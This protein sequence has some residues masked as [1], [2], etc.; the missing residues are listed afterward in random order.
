MLVGLNTENYGRHPFIGR[1]RQAKKMNH[2]FLKKE[3][4]NIDDLLEITRI[5][6]APGGCHWDAEQTHESVKKNLIEETYEVVEAINK[7]DTELLKEE[8]GDVLLQVVFHTQMEQEV[9]AFTFDEVC[10]GVCKKLIIRHP[11]VF[12]D[13][14][15]EDTDTILKNWDEIK[16][17]VKGQKSQSE[18]MDSI[19]REL[20]ALMRAQ[21]IQQKAAK[22]G[23]DWDNI[24]GAIEKCQEELAELDTARQTGTEDEV[25]E[26][27]GDVLFSVVNVARFLSADS[28]EAL[29]SAT[30]KFIRRFKL[31]E[32]FA[33]T[34][35]ID[36]KSSTIEE[37][38]LL[39][40][41]A[42]EVLSR[43]NAE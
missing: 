39:W 38:D 30:D 2:N 18:V 7:K 10:D 21:K 29:T 26:E 22:A 19:P 20:P 28:E 37:L 14:V 8:L 34:R 13:V 40:D 4:Y 3:H 9:D 41:E 17:Q 24:E 33:N 31:V 16:K 11:H 25:L 36:M 1:V 43:G 42:K 15:A 23:F 27:L 5:L 12:G 32:S 6:R 35:G